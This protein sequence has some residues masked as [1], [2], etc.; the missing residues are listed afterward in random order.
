MNKVQQ[1]LLMKMQLGNIKNILIA[2]QSQMGIR[3][4]GIIIYSR[5]MNC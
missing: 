2:K 3:R 4:D 1:Q 5:V